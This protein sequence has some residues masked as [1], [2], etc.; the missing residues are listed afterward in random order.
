MY[1]KGLYENTQKPHLAKNHTM[2][3]V[4]SCVNVKKWEKLSLVIK[5]DLIMFCKRSRI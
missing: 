3:C 1:L 2:C 4:K 5:T